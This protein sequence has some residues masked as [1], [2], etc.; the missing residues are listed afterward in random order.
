MVAYCQKEETNKNANYS[1]N[2][3]QLLYS[4]N[5]E[6]ERKMGLVYL[7][8][9]TTAHNALL[10]LP[11]HIS[12]HSPSTFSILPSDCKPKLSKPSHPVQIQ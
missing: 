5:Y 2:N 6:E 4:K 8:H 1:N 11:P 3:N 9:I 10:C 12:I 7:H